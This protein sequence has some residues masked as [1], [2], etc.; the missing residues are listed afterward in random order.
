MR[1]GFTLIELLVV[2]A[3]IALLVSILLPSLRRAQQMARDLKCKTNLHGYGQAGNMYTNDNNGAFPNST[4]WLFQHGNGNKG[5]Y[6]PKIQP[7]GSLWPYLSSQDIHMCPVFERM[8]SNIRYSYVQNAFVGG[9]GWSHINDP[10]LPKRIM[11][12]QVFNRAGTCFFTEE[13]T[14]K[15]SGLSTASRNDTNLRL[16]GYPGHFDYPL[17]CF[18]TYHDPPG[19]D[20]NKGSANYV[21][22]DGH[23]GVITAAQQWN[24]EGVRL[25]WP[26]HYL[27]DWVKF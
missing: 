25:V 26:L 11:I 13:N 18:A 5:L 12:G 8:H 7:D 24:H 10:S 16:F 27:P 4:D 22:V 15:I 2:I 9:D 21:C 1:K 3:I 17:D 14:W 23:V 19:G 20:L 6:D